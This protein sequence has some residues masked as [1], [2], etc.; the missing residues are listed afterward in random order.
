VKQWGVMS[1]SIAVIL[2]H[3]LQ[4][5]LPS[6]KDRGQTDR[7]PLQHTQTPPL[8]LVSASPRRT[9]YRASSQP[10]TS[11]QKH[12]TA[13]IKQYWR[14]ATIDTRAGQT[15]CIDLSA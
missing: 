7:V 2:C 11:P 5:K 3:F 1:R 6:L 14:D 8:L 9:P 12:T 10:M 15:L 4:E 13:A